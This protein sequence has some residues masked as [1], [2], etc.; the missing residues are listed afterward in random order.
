[1]NCSPIQY[2]YVDYATMSKELAHIPEGL[3]KT[4]PRK[5]DYR[6][7]VAPVK[8]SYKDELLGDMTLEFPV[9]YMTDFGSVPPFLRGIVSHDSREMLV[10]SLA[11]DYLYQSYYL[12]LGETA[13]KRGWRHANRVFLQLLQEA[14]MPKWKAMIAY[15]GVES[16]FG[17]GCY[18]NRSVFDK[19]DSAMVKVS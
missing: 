9:G 3:F 18:K 17:W 1:M 5:E 12:E 13:T 16:P 19:L 7:L 8:L 10:A 6:V 15:L 11:H 4:V 14:G 2:R